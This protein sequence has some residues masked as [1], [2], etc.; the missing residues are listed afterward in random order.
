MIREWWSF[1]ILREVFLNFVFKFSNI[2]TKNTL[3]QNLSVGPLIE[4]ETYHIF[5][6]PPYHSWVSFPLANRSSS[7]NLDLFT[8]HIILPI[9][10]LLPVQLRTRVLYFPI[11]KNSDS[12]SSQNTVMADVSCLVTSAF[13]Y[14]SLVFV[15]SRNTEWVS[16]PITLCLP[17][18]TQWYFQVRYL[19]FLSCYNRIHPS[20]FYEH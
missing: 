20:G 14:F 15:K 13:C 6:W 4:L 9:I 1:E 19:G 11:M 8:V 12:P 18:W 10:Y 5:C 2:A 3:A 17:H 7:K 16:V